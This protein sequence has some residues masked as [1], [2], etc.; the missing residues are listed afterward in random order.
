MDIKTVAMRI[1]STGYVCDHCLGRQFAQLL[2]GYSNAER[3]RIVRTAFAMDLENEDN[4]GSI[5]ESN[6]SDIRFRKRKAPSA[7]PKKPKDCTVCKGIFT[8]I[9]A[10]AKRAIE[11]T[12]DFEYNTFQIGTT[13]TEELIAIEEKLWET[14]GTDF[15]ETIKTEI[16]REVGKVFSKKAGKTVDLK[17]PDMVILF[18]LKTNTVRLTI[19]PLYI[20]GKYKKLAKIPQTRL[21]CY[22]CRGLGCKK[23]DF[24]G[25]IHE[26]SVQELIAEPLLRSTE[27]VDTSFHG[28]GREDIDV[29]C[30][31]GRNFVIE[32]VEPKKRKISLKRLETS[33]NKKNKG[34]IEISDLEFADKNKV[35]AVKSAKARKTYKVIVKTDSAV[36]KTSLKKLNE[37]VTVIKQ[38]T[39]TR[40]VHRRA[41]I[42]RKRSVYSLEHKF[43]DKTHVELVIQTEAGLYIKELVSGDEGRS[44]PSVSALLGVKAVVENLEVVGFED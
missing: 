36:K 33:V 26:T 31:G 5:D 25:K 30:L 24:K 22:D 10:L 17:N 9:N 3:G 32:V 38:Q 41:D 2:S 11:E 19:A 15:C 8:K 42:I 12:E 7:E 14:A 35:I 37:L 21:M 20:F 28:A 1:L 43:I 44:R 40:V 39:P 4:A 16:N 6:F 29:L 18:D 13:P 34:V 27:G 23:C